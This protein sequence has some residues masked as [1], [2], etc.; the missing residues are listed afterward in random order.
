MSGAVAEAFPFSNNV[1]EDGRDV[2]PRVC[3]HPKSG[4]IEA[5]GCACRRAKDAAAGAV[6]HRERQALLVGD[7]SAHAPTAE[8]WIVHEAVSSSPGYRKR[9]SR[10]GGVD[11]QSRHALCSAPRWLDCCKCRRRSGRRE[12]HST[13]P[14]SAS[15]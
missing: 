6:R 15:R 10:P 14:C 1:V 9:N 12:W 11:D 13:R 3:K 7:D 4:C 8:N 5:L 2:V